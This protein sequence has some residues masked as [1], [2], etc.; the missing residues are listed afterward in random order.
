MEVIPNYKYGF[1]VLV[2]MAVTQLGL[3]ED[4]VVSNTSICHPLDGI[5]CFKLHVLCH[6]H[7]TFHEK[8]YYMDLY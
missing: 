7:V 4:F 3:I 8:Q 2:V 6:V 1:E 5:V